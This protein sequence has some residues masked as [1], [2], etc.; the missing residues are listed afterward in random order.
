[1]PEECQHLWRLPRDS[2]A[3]RNPYDNTASQME[4]ANA[5]L[6]RRRNYLLHGV[7]ALDMIKITSFAKLI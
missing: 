1:L 5:S 3:G 7:A 6:H 2:G 4:T